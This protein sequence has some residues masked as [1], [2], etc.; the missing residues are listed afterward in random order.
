MNK[1]EL[2]EFASEREDTL[3][4]TVGKKY[5]EYKDAVE[6]GEN[7]RAEKIEEEVN[8]L[9]K[10]LRLNHPNAKLDEEELNL[11][12]MAEDENFKLHYKP[13]YKNQN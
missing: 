12:M 4:D 7:E 9:L 5:L 3:I 1:Y 11:K 2:P 8:S 10:E 6:H 13:D